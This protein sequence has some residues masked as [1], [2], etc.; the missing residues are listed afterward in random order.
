MSCHAGPNVMTRGDI[1]QCVCLDTPLAFNV[2]GPAPTM[3]LRPAVGF[4]AG[5]QLFS[6][7]L[8]LCDDEDFSLA[9]RYVDPAI[10]VKLTG[11]LQAA[12]C[13]FRKFFDLDDELSLFE[14][15][16][17][18]VDLDAIADS[19]TAANHV[20]GLFLETCALTARIMRRTLSENLHSF[21][22]PANNADLL[23]IY[24]NTR[25]IGLKAWSGLPY[26][27]V[28]VSV[29]PPYSVLYPGLADNGQESYRLCY[30]DWRTNEIILH[31]RGCTLCIQLRVLPDGDL[32]GYVLFPHSMTGYLCE[33]SAADLHLPSSCAHELPPSPQ[34]HRRP[35][36]S[37][38]RTVQHRLP[39]SRSAGQVPERGS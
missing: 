12:S 2:L 17:L 15:L 22:D 10:D 24:D 3:R 14:D 16:D 21:N 25:F 9:A 32:S 20:S 13:P 29:L 38:G 19:P 27:Y 33:G 26:V 23:A 8:L 7:P 6:C 39:I 34:R 18:A 11:V 5:D 37:P 36:D 4:L 30:L 35:W 1:L 28:W 31:R